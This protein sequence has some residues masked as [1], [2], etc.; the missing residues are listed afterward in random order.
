[1]RFPFS[2]TAARLF[3]FALVSS[4][5]LL[6][7]ACG[8]DDPTPVV[9][10]AQD[11]SATDEAIIRKYLSD[12]SITTAVRQSNGLYFLPVVTNANAYMPRTGNLVYVKYTGRLI[13]GTVFDAT[14]MHGNVPINFQL[15][16]GRVIAGWD[17]GIALMHK[18]DRAELLIPSALGYGNQSP[19]PAIPANS[20]LRFEVELTDVR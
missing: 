9:P 19:S 2:A 4:A 14:S 7:V 10:P 13:N 17:Q 20:V 5:S 12:N 16:A 6:T 3:F 18:G 8:D 11:F 1:M 15:G